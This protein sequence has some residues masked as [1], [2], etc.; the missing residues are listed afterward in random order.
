MFW[1][2]WQL[3]ETQLRVLRWLKVQFD[4][5]LQ[6]AWYR[7]WCKV[8]VLS[9]CIMSVHYT[10]R[11][12]L[13]RLGVHWGLSWVHQ[14]D[15]LS[16]PRGHPEYTDG[17]HKYYYSYLYEYMGGGGG[18]G[19]H[20]ECGGYHEHTKGCSVHQMDSM[21][22]MMSVGEYHEYVGDI[23]SPLTVLMISSRCTEH[24]L[25]YCTLLHKHYAG[26]L[27]CD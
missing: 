21:N 14:G 15:T 22:T 18:G 5:K 13:T 9:P 7:Q 8:S 24:P 11:I 19:C 10:G 1:N 20:D 25:V 6:W 26:C 27:H 4:F 17:Y 2:A 12:S 3:Q 16:T 23:L